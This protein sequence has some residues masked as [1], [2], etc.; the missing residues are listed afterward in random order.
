[1]TASER[2][3]QLL[4][5]GLKELAATTPLRKVRVGELCER[6]GVD[7]RT[8]YYHFRDVY[9]LAA[10]IF[11][12]NIHLNLQLR[13]GNPTE[14]GLARVLNR[15]RKDDVFY[16]CALSEDSQNALG[17]HFLSSTVQMYTALVLRAQGKTELSEEEDFTIGYHCFGTLGTVRR[18]IMQEPERSPEEMARLLLQTM[19]PLISSLY[20]QN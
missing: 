2:T 8:F 10:W 18:W 11:D 9:D 4:A 6:C 5:R 3:K 20:E 14:I 1:M 19:P 15:F 7:R 12:Q 13:E 17:R 16:R